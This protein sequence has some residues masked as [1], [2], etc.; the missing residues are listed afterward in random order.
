MNGSHRFASKSSE[1]ED[2]WTEILGADSFKR[3]RVSRIY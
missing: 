1:V 2:L 3:P